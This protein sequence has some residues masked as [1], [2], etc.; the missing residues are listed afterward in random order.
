MSG[1]L[2]GY[3]KAFFGVLGFF[4]ICGF[5]VVA[6]LLVVFPFFYLASLHEG[7]YT[8]ACSSFF[9]LSFLFLTIRKVMR[10]YSTSPRKLAA[11]FVK[12]SIALLGLGAF[13][14]LTLLFYRLTAILAFILFFVLY[15]LLAPLLS[16]WAEG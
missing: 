7:V 8:I 4:L 15:L 13:I 3:K 14:F 6:S 2:R 1:I 5:C 16:K 12:L 10:V 9:V 11:F